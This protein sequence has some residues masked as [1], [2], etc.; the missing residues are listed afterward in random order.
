MTNN[1]ESRK[2]K[3]INFRMTKKSEKVLIENEI[4]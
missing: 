2:D 3:N 1:P 4:P